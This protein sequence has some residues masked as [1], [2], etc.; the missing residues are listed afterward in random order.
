MLSVSEIEVL[1][2]GSGPTGLTLAI[3]L[4]RRGILACA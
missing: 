1:I 4:A 3:D 2:V